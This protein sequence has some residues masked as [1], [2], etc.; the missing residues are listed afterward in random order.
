MVTHVLNGFESVEQ[1]LLMMRDK[2]KDMIKP[3]VIV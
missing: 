2:P 1:A 3:V